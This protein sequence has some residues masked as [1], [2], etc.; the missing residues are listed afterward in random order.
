MTAL[1]LG[2]REIP[3]Q[4]LDLS[5]LVPDRLAGASAAEIERVELQT[6]RERVCV[7]DLFRVRMGDVQRIHFEGGHNRFDRVGCGMSVGEIHIEG[8]VGCQAGR[9]MNGGKLVIAG[10]AGPWAA[11]GM[12]KGLVE[13]GGNAGERLGGP[14]AGETTGMRGGVV[15][16]RKNAGARAGDRLRRG[17]IVVEGDAAAYAGSR[18]I[19]GTLMV[20][21]RAEILPGYLMS[22]GTIVLAGKS[23]VL[24]PTFVD[25]GVHELLSNTLMAAFIRPY[26]PALAAFVRRPLRRLM[27]D[28]AGIGKGEILCPPA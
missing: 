25:C 22:R 9:L 8:D 18:M 3:A 19:A 17:T 11:S 20:G 24:S 26:S 21:G 14:L 7:G 12:K 2:L 1:V 27:G 10:D 5:P 16:V 6:T 28:M 23:D 4:R 15:I 13:I